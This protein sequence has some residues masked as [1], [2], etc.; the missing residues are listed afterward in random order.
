M[1]WGN[2]LVIGMLVGGALNLL[3]RYSSMLVKVPDKAQY[4]Y[5]FRSQDVRM[6]TQHRSI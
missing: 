6:Y 1:G 3:Q 4:F 2:P 5:S